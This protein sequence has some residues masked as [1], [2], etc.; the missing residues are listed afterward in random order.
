M[1]QVL[2]L[3]TMPSLNDYIKALKKFRL[4]GQAMKTDYTDATHLACKHQKIKPYTVPVKLE[5][6]YIEKNAKR[7]PDNIVFCKKFILDGMV[8]A[9][10]IPNDTQKYIKTWTEEWM[11]DKNNPGIE[12]Y[13]EEWE[14]DNNDSLLDAVCSNGT[15]N[16]V[17]DPRF[18]N[19][20]ATSTKHN[21]GV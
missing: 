8:N 13:I 3:K 21:E 19:N 15:I 1:R 14:D 18:S 11:V 5:F 9:G 10:I 16:W 2:Y 20:S 4:V 17:D 12:V 7:D 6:V